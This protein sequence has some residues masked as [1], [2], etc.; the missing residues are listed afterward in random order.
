LHANPTWSFVY[1]DVIRALRE[2][3]R[4]VL[5]SFGPLSRTV[6]RIARPIVRR[7]SVNAREEIR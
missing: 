7:E 4:S 2:Q 3:F 1:R 5:M 6:P